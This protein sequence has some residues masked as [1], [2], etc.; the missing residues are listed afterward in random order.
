MCK[1]IFT[2]ETGVKRRKKAIR[3]HSKVYTRRQV[4]LRTTTRTLFV[5]V[6]VKVIY[7]DMNEIMFHVIMYK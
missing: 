2:L 1:P 3:K 7:L 6:N 4:I 5:V